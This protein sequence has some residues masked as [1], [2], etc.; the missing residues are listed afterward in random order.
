MQ[1]IRNSWELAKVSWSVLR[2]DKSLAVFPLLSA[3]AGLAVV[4]VVAGL[5]AATGVNS[6][7]GGSLKGI[8]YVFIAAGYIASAFVTTYFLGALVH[9]ANEALEGRHAELGECFGAANSRLHR[10]LPWALVQATVSIVIQALESQ[11]L[12]G[13][14]VA[15]LIGTAWAVLTFLTVPIIMLEDLG[16]IVAV[17]R[18]GQLLRRSWGENLTAQ[19]GFGIF[20]FVALLPAALLVAIGAA[21]G[22]LV[23]VIALA[24][25]AVAWALVTILAV[26]A[27][28]G[29]YRTAL[30]RFAVDGVAPPAFAGADLQHA[31]GPRQN[32]PGLGFG[33]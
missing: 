5:I 8:G 3:L 25:V 17:K 21:T 29:I 10:I 24:T 26:S 14:I 12:I 28:S 1:R 9:G 30:Y 16:P 19:V 18:S 23:V 7:N 33:G 15:S 11:R 13:Q 31:L 22:S 32:R 6:A 20:G 27:L 2:S 4:G